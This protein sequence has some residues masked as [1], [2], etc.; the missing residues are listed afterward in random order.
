VEVIDHEEAA[1]L[2]VFAEACS[3]GIG[4][5]P[6]ADADRIEE[7]PVKDLIAIDIDDFLDGTGVDTVR[8]RIAFM[9]RR[10]DLLESVPQRA[11][12]RK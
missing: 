8:R 11:K 12:R 6:V 10:S 4:E 3:L 7:W 5:D 1:A 9:K 2:E